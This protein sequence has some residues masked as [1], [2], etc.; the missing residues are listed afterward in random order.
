MFRA[1]IALVRMLRCTDLSK[2]S[3]VIHVKNIEI[4]CASYFICSSESAMFN[5]LEEIAKSEEPC[6]PVLGGRISKAL[7]PDTV[8]DDVSI[9]GYRVDAANFVRFWMRLQFTYLQ[10]H[11]WL[12]HIRYNVSVPVLYLSTSFVSRFV[13]G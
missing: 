6:T 8:Y 2:L 7:E 3:L 13:I 4:L 5:R 11:T 9:I 10:L 12:C 1:V